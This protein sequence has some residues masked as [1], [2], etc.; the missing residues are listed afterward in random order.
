MLCTAAKTYGEAEVGEE[1]PLL[2]QKFALLGAS[3]MRKV[4]CFLSAFRSVPYELN[5]VANP[6]QIHISCQMSEDETYR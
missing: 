5:Y 2:P 6:E 3:I 1:S 4:P